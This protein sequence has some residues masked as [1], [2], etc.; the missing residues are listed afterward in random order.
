MRLK[1][2]TYIL[3]TL[4]LSLYGTGKEMILRISKPP[5]VQKSIFHS[6]MGFSALAG[7]KYFRKRFYF[8]FMSWSSDFPRGWI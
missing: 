1:I 7:L 6:A 4:F 8:I 5:Y 2:I 3:S